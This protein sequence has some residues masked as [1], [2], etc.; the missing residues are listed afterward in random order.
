MNKK[1]LLVFLGLS[2]GITMIL[3]AIARWKGM[4]LFDGNLIQS[5]L[6]ILGAMFLP[7]LSAIFTQWVVLKKPI[8]SLGFEIGPPVAYLYCFLFVLGMF[9]IHYGITWLWILPPDFTLNHFM[10]EYSIEGGLPLPAWQM[11][12]SFMLV[13]LF[14]SPLMNLIPS[15]GEE[16]GWR[17]FLLPLLKPAGEI[18]AVIGSAMIWALWHTPMIIF[19]GFGY[20]HQIWPG[21]LL[22][23]LMVTGL[24]MVMGY[25]WLKTR[26]VLLAGFMHGVFNGHAYGVWSMIFVS[27][28]KVWVGAGSIVGAFLWVLAGLLALQ[29]IRRDMKRSENEYE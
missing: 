29:L 3:I 17:G 25:L 2:F 14:T 7:G 26:S 4:T 8:R 10:Q 20:G 5:Q 19:L 28:N 24:G 6:L 9:V 13:T 11:I 23:F 1:A 16:I 22:H 18:N 12:L 27:Q 21:I 15:L